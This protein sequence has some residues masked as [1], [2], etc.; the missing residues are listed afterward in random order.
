MAKQHKKHKPPATRHEEGSENQKAFELLEKALAH[1][2]VDAAYALGT[3]YLNGHYV[4]Q[5]LKKGLSLIKKAAEKNHPGALHDLAVGHETGIGVKKDEAKALELYT[6]GALYGDAQCHFEVG[7]M[8]YYGIGAR[9]NKELAYAWL[10][11][12]KELGIQE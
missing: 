2:S 8:Y 3:W 6:K 1:G 12:A 7:R 11:R 4:K 10:H 5:S 9:R